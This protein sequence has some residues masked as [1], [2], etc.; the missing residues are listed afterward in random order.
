[1]ILEGDDEDK[2]LGEAWL[3]DEIGAKDA[4]ANLFVLTFYKDWEDD[5][6]C[7][8]DKDNWWKMKFNTYP[9]AFGKDYGYEVAMAAMY[10]GVEIVNTANEYSRYRVGSG[11]PKWDFCQLVCDNLRKQGVNFYQDLFFK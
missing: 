9:I 5:R 1:M 10:D 11:D 2:A 3:I 7:E 4:K 8:I 6:P